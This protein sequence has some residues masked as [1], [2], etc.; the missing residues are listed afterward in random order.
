MS[1][2]RRNTKWNLILALALLAVLGLLWGAARLGLLSWG[3]GTAAAPES[4]LRVDFIDVGQGDA[5]LITCSGEAMLIDAGPVDAGP[6]VTGYLQSRGVSSLAYVVCTHA[7]EDHCGG[8]DDVVE[9]FPVE[10]LF[11]PYTEFDDSG[12]F[13]YFENAAADAGLET[14]VPALGSVYTLGDASFTFVG[15]VSESDSVND[16]SLVLRLDYGQTA[17]LFPG[18]ASVQALSDDLAAGYDLS[19]D[20]LKLSH[21]GSSDGL[22][23][24]LLERLSPSLAVACVGAGNDYGHPHREVLALLEE[25]GIPLLRTDTDG[26]VSVVSDGRTVTVLK[27]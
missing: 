7:H 19:C 1:E 18:D 10:T 27:S 5:I 20:V 13:T 6:A 23:E 16:T 17:F 21:H 8:L 12:T 25:K 26:T 4:S 9:R 15:P 11:A 24:T 2:K 3:G 22:D 14:Q